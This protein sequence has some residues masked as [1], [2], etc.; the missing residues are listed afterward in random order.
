MEKKLEKRDIFYIRL[1][2]LS[3]E[4]KKSLNKIEKELGYP[5]NSLNNYKTG[6]RVPSAKRLFEL[7]GYFDVTPE[8]LSGRSDHKNNTTLRALY[9]RL[10]YD[11]KKEL[12][13]LSLEW[14]KKEGIKS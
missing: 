14:V 10:E 6:A 7:A 11:E 12:Y 1:K 9:Q 4:K 5:R 8:Y 13:N 2:K 3:I